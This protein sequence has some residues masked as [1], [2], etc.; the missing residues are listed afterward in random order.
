MV[1]MKKSYRFLVGKPDGKTHFEN[2]GIDER[3]I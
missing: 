1:E 3:M 2:L